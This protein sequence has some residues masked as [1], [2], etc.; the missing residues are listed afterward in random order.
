MKMVKMIKELVQF[1]VEL[2]FRSPYRSTARVRVVKGLLW[3]I[4]GL[5]ATVIA[6]RLIRGL[7]A[8]TNL[9]DVTPWGLWI[10]FDVVGGV[11]LAAGG[12]VVA[13]TVEI[14]HL[15]RYH[16][17]VRP[18][19]LTAFLG[20]GAV[21]VSLVFDL[22]LWFNIWR[23]MFFWQHHSALFEVAWC[24]M[25]YFTVLALEFAPVVLEK[26]P[27]PR[28]FKFMK[29]IT[30]P[31][32]ILG[33]ML[34]TLH[35]SSLGTLF[36]IMPFR[37]HPLWYSSLQPLL[38]FVSA[39]G[40]GLAMVTLESLVSG[41]L[42]RR[43]DEIPLLAGLAKAGAVVLG[44][45]TVIRLGDLA[46]AGKLG[47]LAL[48]TW[49]SAVFILEMLLCAIIPM[50]LFAVPQVRRRKA[51]LFIG[52]AT[53]VIGFVFNRINVAGIST[54]SATGTNYI[55]SWTEFAVSAAVV[56]GAALVFFFFIEHFSVYEDDGPKKEHF[57]P[58]PD[59]VTGAFLASPWMGNGA[60][61]SLI[62]ILAA[63]IAAY[64]LPEDAVS[65]AK[66]K[67]TPVDIVRTV[68][69][70]KS[71]P[72]GQPFSHLELAAG[73][74][75]PS[76]GARSLQVLLLDANRDG[77]F[78]LFDHAGHQ[79]RQGK[80]SCGF[81]HHRNRPF[82]QATP[83]SACH[84]DMYLAT[85]VF[86]HEAHQRKTGGNQGCPQCHPDP[87]LPKTRANTTSCGSCHRAMSVSNSFVASADHPLDQPAAGFMDAMH[88]L[89]RQCHMDAAARK[90]EL[91]ADFARC[92]ACHQ[93][94]GPDYLRG[95]P[96]YPAPEN[97]SV[98]GPGRQGD[99][100]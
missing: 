27:F 56:S 88:G 30:L 24:V 100:P 99:G 69:A 17:I 87:A 15:H 70:I 11:A 7:G 61:Y 94:R 74:A 85:D 8:T 6:A 68:T 12:F 48:P 36:L 45:Y 46:A 62:F 26:M 14:F 2:A 71:L 41:W 83:C 50:I 92:T 75:P 10:G 66:P 98:S 51:G 82:D 33:I 43:P 22:G 20:Y 73:D 47:L 37:L 25:L 58:R 3:F 44:I 9:T 57:L 59:P 52:A 81:C 89:C 34:S 49:E 79:Q 55:P 80:D 19:V 21:C 64:L 96:G 97:H 72:P 53:A 84:R 1:A 38:F 76:A 31:L 54:I 35:Q 39:I 67:P 65:G 78:V 60:I 23:P 5:G 40:L 32:V 91:S 42:Y 63:G 95:L 77:R 18:A 28:V 4:C 90:P 13:A 29:A 93:Q 86:N 16:A